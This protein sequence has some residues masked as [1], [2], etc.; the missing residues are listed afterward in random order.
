MALKFNIKDYVSKDNLFKYNAMLQKVMRDKLDQ[1]ESRIEG[2]VNSKFDTLSSEKQSFAEVVDSRDGEE[3]LSKRLNRDKKELNTKI[4]NLLETVSYY[5]S[6]ENN[7]INIQNSKEG[8]LDNIR[9]EGN[10]L[11][12]LAS[13]SNV[14]IN[15][16][17]GVSLS[18][19]M[20]D[21]M[22]T[23]GNL[24]LINSTTNNVIY[25][26]YDLATAKWRRNAKV[27]AGSSIYVQL[28]SDEYIGNIVGQ[29]VDGWEDSEKSKAEFIK[30]KFIIEGDYTQNP[31]PYFEGVKSV[32][33][34][35]E[36]EIA[37]VNASKN[38]INI[39][40]IKNA[41]GEDSRCIVT[42][43]GF[44]TNYSLTP[45]PFPYY[46]INNIGQSYLNCNIVQKGDN[47]TIRGYTTLS[48]IST[49]TNY[50][51]NKNIGSLGDISPIEIPNGTKYIVFHR[52][53]SN[54]GEVEISN[55]SVTKG[56]TP[57]IV[58]EIDKKKL[59]YKDSD[60]TWKPAILKKVSEDCKDYI[61]ENNNGKSFYYKKCNERIL[62]GS[63]SGT[64]IYSEKTNTITFQ[65]SC[66]DIFLSKEQTVFSDKFS[67][68]YSGF[69][70]PNDVESISNS[71][72]YSNIYITI[73]KTKL[74]T[75]DVTGFKKWLRA[76]P[77]TVIYS[78]AQ[79]KV[80]DCINLDLQSFDVE[81]NIFTN[82]SIPHKLDI[83]Q[84]EGLK[85]KVETLEQ[86]VNFVY[87][88]VKPIF[89]IKAF[90]N[91][92]KFEYS[93][94]TNGYLKFPDVFGGLM[95][96]WGSVTFTDAVLDKT[97]VLP[98][99][100][101]YRCIAEYVSLHGRDGN[102]DARTNFEVYNTY[103]GRLIVKN[104]VEGKENEVSWF[105]IG[106]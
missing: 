43:T 27:S 34:L 97:V 23:I 7:Y 3:V 87:D 54:T 9:L 67:Y 102:F 26:I 52:A 2:K 66:N 92:I 93:L 72:K 39:A 103:Q 47:I 8:A 79:E 35:E 83:T 99:T 25:G 32:G 16:K 69:N 57:N 59:L 48:D 10:T 1:Y 17:T 81:T 73:A 13:R 42:K 86:E 88:N 50:T 96:Q 60:D 68:L 101:K 95:I 90:I 58:T 38:L 41:K 82:S 20:N 37:S 91:S 80:Y 56:Q 18:F 76:N 40:D 46:E 104:N 51:F 6:S 105:T 106:Y 22:T 74:E 45:V 36:L 98:V 24:T 84:K 77:V 11:V 61:E 94:N 19:T 62:K 44:K 78:L 75:Q 14:D 100:Y 55:I 33:E 12:N 63:E 28:N 21:N 85:A 30:T 64:S 71:P 65:I 5:Y 89:D 31:P 15:V 53:N 29:F 70:A 4:D 49:L